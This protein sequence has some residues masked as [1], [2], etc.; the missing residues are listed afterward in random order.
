MTLGLGSTTV[1]LSGTSSTTTQLAPTLTLLPI[2]TPGRIFAPAPI[3]TLSRI[4]PPP[5]A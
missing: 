1:Q 5:H 3:I 2:V 4:L